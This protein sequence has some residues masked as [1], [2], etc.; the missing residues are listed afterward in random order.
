MTGTRRNNEVTKHAVVI[1]L[2]CGSP[3]KGGQAMRNK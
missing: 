1:M 2:V 3:Q